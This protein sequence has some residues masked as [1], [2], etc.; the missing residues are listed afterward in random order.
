M[1]TDPLT[2]A[3]VEQFLTR[4]FVVLRDCFSREAAAQL[5]DQI[6]PRLGYDPHDR[7]TWKQS[8]VHMPARQRFEIETFAPKAWEA[9]CFLCGGEERIARPARWSDAFIVNFN[10]GADQ[11]WIPPSPAAP[12]W[13][14][15]GD[16]FM[17]FLDSPE[18]ALLTIVL[19][20]DVEPKGGGTFLACDSVP[21]VARYLADHP[22]GVH[23][24]KFPNESFV[25]QCHDFVEATGRVGDVYLMH[26]YMIH[27]SSFNHSDRVRI[28]TNPPIALK[29]PMR[30]KRD[31]P[32][33]YS[34]VELAVLR[35]LGVSPEQGYDFRPTAPR[36]KIVPERVRIQQQMLEEEAKRLGESAS[37]QNF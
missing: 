3:Q 24:F 13:H 15:D 27:A 4:G 35:G 7:S 23:P 1:A 9:I 8:R 25:A 37:V 29:E 6:W 21:H 36:E 10:D 16:F 2:P 33:E 31:N 11:E 30:F 18:Q 22:E 34:P 17:H 12:G 5:T 14:K 32:A 19:W 26:P 20:S 28:I